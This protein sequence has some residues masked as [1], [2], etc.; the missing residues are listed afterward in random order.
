MMV[1]RVI[2]VIIIFCVFCTPA[3]STLEELVIN[4]DFENANESWA[5]NWTNINGA[6]PNIS[7]TNLSSDGVIG[8]RSLFINDTQTG[9]A[10][11]SERRLVQLI[12]IPDNQ[13]DNAILTLN[14]FINA[15]QSDATHS[16][17]I[18]VWRSNATS[19]YI[20]YL[21]GQTYSNASGYT[22]YPSVNFSVP[23]GTT[24][25]SIVLF[26]GIDC[27]THG[28]KILVDN[29][30][31]QGTSAG[32]QSLWQ[33]SSFP[34]NK[35]NWIDF[36]TYMFT[37]DGQP[38]YCM[39]F[40]TTGE[41]FLR[42]WCTSEEW[43]VMGFL[44]DW[45]LRYLPQYCLQGT[46]Y[47]HTF[48]ILYD[49]SYSLNK[50][51]DEG[52]FYLTYSGNI[53][54]QYY[55]KTLYDELAIQPY[56]RVNSSR[57][58]CYFWNGIYKVRNN[59]PIPLTL[60]TYGTLPTIWFKESMNNLLVHSP[61]GFY[62]TVP[63]NLTF[64]VDFYNQNTGG[65]MFE[66]N[67][68]MPVGYVVHDN[69]TI[70]YD[71]IIDASVNDSTPYQ[72]LP[73]LPQ[74]DVDEVSPAYTI[75]LAFFDPRVIF[76]VVALTVVIATGLFTGSAGLSALVMGG[77]IILGMSAGAVAGIEIIPAWVGFMLMVF[78][79]GLIAL[80]FKSTTAHD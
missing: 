62:C 24:H 50:E 27:A 5:Y 52:S 26:T 34:Q 56:I 23:E 36:G 79:A 30:S 44:W 68:T 31:I 59:E 18:Q 29:I 2:L 46:N 61:I 33:I 75:G 39:R 10:T 40:N 15:S 25:L 55:T 14:S 72:I 74:V 63:S 32:N 38:Y 57:T 4:G 54:N 41:G 12:D 37:N 53:Y 70:D 43:G 69:G 58:G 13:Y 51:Y 20:T 11:C 60:G 42:Q 67:L 17:N 66:Q 78:S 35:E 9:E 65:K 19:T 64:T 1:S 3:L 45:L 49:D 7:Y 76:L 22:N 48:H 21:I 71:T 6:Y 80:F 47:C 28:G 77:M 16:L 73:A 8:A